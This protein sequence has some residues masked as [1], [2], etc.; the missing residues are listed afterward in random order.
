MK[1]KGIRGSVVNLAGG[2]AVSV[3]ALTGF[4]ATAA[5]ELIYATDFASGDL[6]SFFSDAP[7]SILTDVAI[8]GLQ[9]NEVMRGIDFQNGT[10]YGVGSQSR[11]YTIN[12]AS[13]AA[14]AVGPAFTPVLNGASF[15]VDNGPSGVVVISN[16][17]QNLTIDRTPG[18]GAATVGP[19]VAY[20]VGDPNA[21]S[22]P[23]ITGLAFTGTNW[24][25]AN[26]A[27]NS[28]ALLNPATGVLTTIGP[29]GIDFSR[30]N[31]L[32]FSF[33]SGITYLGSPA[34][35]SDPQAN[36]YTVNRVTGAVTLI[37]LIG[38]PGDNILVGGLAVVPEPSAVAIL[39][40]GGLL[41]VAFRRR[42]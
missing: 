39:A 13:G 41:L 24:I 33:L 6:F 9:N 20:A 18:S 40:V 36:L 5:H 42:R 29:S 26:S 8:T 12:L 25:A 16:L 27:L 32:D 21:A 35:S 2:L 19:A 28:F 37:G 11:L 34:A 17:R 30:N 31:G 1:S 38:L 23:V 4:K 14:T 10:L 3:L 7:G 15:G 22:T